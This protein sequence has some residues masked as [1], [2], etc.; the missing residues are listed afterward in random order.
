MKYEV[1]V[2]WD[3]T[4]WSADPDFS[5][6]YD[7]I[8]GDLAEDSANYIDWSRGKEREQGN[9]P[10]GTLNVRMKAGLCNK[11]SPWTAGILVGKIRP[12]LP[13]RIR[14]DI[15]GFDLIPVYSGFISRISINP[16]KNIQSVS[17]YCTDGMDLLARQ[18]VTQDSS[19]KTLMSDGDAIDKILDTG[20]WSTTRRN[21][22]KDGGDELLGY[23][24]TTIY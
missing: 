22:A 15:E 1:C 16:H 9:A 12:W 23:P 14:G 13:I 19:S 7:N 4:D 21:I 10:A 3:A 2:D 6:D 18:K 5:E 20:G 11:Y 8:S 24:S 17:F